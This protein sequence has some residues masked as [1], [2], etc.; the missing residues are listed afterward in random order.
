MCNN[1]GILHIARTTGGRPLCNKRNA[2]QSCDFAA[3]RTGAWS[4][5][6]VRCVA[7][8]AKMDAVKARN[9]ARTDQKFDMLRAVLA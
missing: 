4:R 8:V 7:I 5:Y 9:E 1:Q 6:C 2:H 3:Y